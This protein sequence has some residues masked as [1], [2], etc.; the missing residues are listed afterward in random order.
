MVALLFLMVLT[1]QRPAQLGAAMNLNCTGYSV[2]ETLYGSF[3]RA[4]HFIQCTLNIICDNN[5]IQV[6]PITMGQTVA[7]LDSN[8]GSKEWEK[9]F[10]DLPALEKTAYELTMHV[11]CA[12]CH[13][14]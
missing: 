12:V 8:I 5:N 2:S 4:L 13:H 11:C 9:D 3:A 14:G 10:F 6:P 1:G 7:I